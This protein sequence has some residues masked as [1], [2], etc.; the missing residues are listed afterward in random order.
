MK[1]IFVFFADEIKALGL[2]SGSLDGEIGFAD[3]AYTGL[4][5]GGVGTV[6]AMLP[7]DINIDGNFSG[8]TVLLRGEARGKTYFGRLLKPAL[9]F[10]FTRPVLL[11]IKDFLFTKG[12]KK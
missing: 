2:Q 5:L 9:K 8:K 3:P 12:D 7:L 1:K 11:I 4:M 10:I 6:R